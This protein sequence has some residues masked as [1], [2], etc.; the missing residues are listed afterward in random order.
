MATQFDGH[1]AASPVKTLGEYQVARKTTSSTRITPT[2][3]RLTPIVPTIPPR[4]GALQGG[5]GSTRA[6]MTS[7]STVLF[8]F[9]LLTANACAAISACVGMQL[10]TVAS[11]RNSIS[12][13]PRGPGS[14]S[15]PVLR[16]KPIMAVAPTKRFAPSGHLSASQQAKAQGPRLHRDA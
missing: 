7:T 8:A 2:L 16:G 1:P 12:T 9:I 13:G 4:L 3:V 15:R 6:D 10:A 14:L 5:L 11:N